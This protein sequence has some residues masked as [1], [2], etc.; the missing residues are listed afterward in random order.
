MV[1]LRMKPFH[2]V[3]DFVELERDSVGETE[4]ALVHRDSLRIVFEEG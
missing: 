2:V 3:D 4:V 1:I